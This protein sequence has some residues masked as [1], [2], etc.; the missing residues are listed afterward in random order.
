M[1]LSP[2]LNLIGLYQFDSTLFDGLSFPEGIDKD[3]FRDS[4]LLSDGEK[5][6]IHP[7]LP[8][9][10]MAIPVWCMKHEEDFNRIVAALTAEYN[11]I[12]NFDRNETYKDTN[13]GDDVT[14]NALTTTNDLTRT[15][16]LNMESTTSAFNSDEYQPD[17]NVENT[18]TVTN[19]G[20]VDN[21]GTITLTHGHVFEHSGH[22]YGNI[23][24]T[25][26]QEMVEDEIVLRTNRNLYAILAG[27]FVS[28]FCLYEF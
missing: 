4:L 17:N 23:G 19:T 15:D 26:S 9:M 11:P 22:L 25:K 3:I 8:F 7:S 12:H 18:G 28:E 6:L 20:T 21:T 2:R 13:S 10:K 16:N 14:E 24:V 27:M 5:P 1:S